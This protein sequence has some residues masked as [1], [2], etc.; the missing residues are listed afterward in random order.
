MTKFHFETPPM[1]PVRS[2]NVAALGSDAKTVAYGDFSAYY[3]R[4]VGNIVV[5][6][7]DSRYFDTD[8][9]GVRGKWRVDGALID[10]PAVNCLHQNVT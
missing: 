7:D 8:Q 2:S 9:V 1:T 4:T 5:E 3:I 10:T 6:R